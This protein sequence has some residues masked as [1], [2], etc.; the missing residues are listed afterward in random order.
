MCRSCVDHGHDVKLVVADSQGLEI[1]AGVSIVDVGKPRGRLDRVNRTAHHVFIAASALNGDLYHLHDPELIPIGLKLKR[2][3]KRVVFDSHEDFPLQILGKSYLTKSVRRVLSAGAALYERWACRQL[4]G[5]IAA[6]PRIRDKFLRIHPRTIDVCNFP[7]LGELSTGQDWSLKASDVCFV[8][9]CERIRGIV[10]LCTA[11]TLVDE[12]VRLNV[13][14]RFCETSVEDEVKSMPSWA[15]VK[16]Y[17]HADRTTIRDVFQRSVAGLVTLH[18][19][20]NLVDALPVKMFEYMSAGLPVIAS[21]FPL[22]REIIAGNN[23]GLLVDP[24]RPDQ[25]ARAIAE[26]V[27]NPLKAKLMGENGRRAVEERFN[28]ASEAG[29]LMAFYELTPNS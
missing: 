2:R 6:T 7:I 3:G 21:D 12:D 19:V 11:L 17:G 8:G 25:I 9:G 5:V 14:G 22:W 20:P 13:C 28:W 29:K 10:Q 23:C 1:E 26:L 4:D 18:P 24:L 16:H 27:R 15:K